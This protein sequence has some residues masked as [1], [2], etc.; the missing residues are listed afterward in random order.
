MNSS[1]GDTTPSPGPGAGPPD[2]G[3]WELPHRL[4]DDG[5]PA[6]QR[7]TTISEYRAYIDRQVHSFLGYQANQHADYS[8]QLSWMLDRSVNNLGDPYIDG[9]FTVN[10]KAFERDVLDYFARLWRAKGRD[11][12]DLGNAYWGYLLS[13]GSTEAN[14]YGLWNAR[15]YLKG[16]ALVSDPANPERMLWMSAV[17]ASTVDGHATSGADGTAPG[18]TAQFTPVAFYSADTHYSLT[19]AARVLGIPTFAEVGTSAYR[20]QC[21]LGGAWP[22]EVPSV[23]GDAGPGSIDVDKL[24]ELV[25]FFAARGHPALIT[26]NL[27]T[28]FKGAYDPVGEIA[29]RIADIMRSHSMYERILQVP[30]GTTTP[31]TVKR[32]GFWIHVDGALGAAYLPYLRMARHAGDARAADLPPVPEFD[33]SVEDVFSISVS[34]HKWI[35]APWPCGV[36]MTKTKYQLKPPD[37]PAYVGSPDTTFAGSRDGF[38]AVLLWEHLARY[39]QDEQIDRALAAQEIAAYAVDKL[40]ALGKKLRR[41]LYVGRTPLALTVRFLKPVEAVVFKYSLSTETYISDQWVDYAHLFVMPGVTKDLID[42]LIADL[43]ENGAFPE[44]PPITAR[45]TAAVAER[46]TAA[47]PLAGAAVPLTGRGFE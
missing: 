28:T 17:A 37:M 7:A 25:K 15:D 44:P 2:P 12:P 31:T 1:S 3:H 34:G 20:D 42:R 19:K 24:C 29:P 10:S 41:D 16:R 35:G 11:D 36:Y 47:T 21:P 32:H 6:S 27:G 23:G 8:D 14:L 43:G 22:D 40:T 9:N 13:M 33:F 46:R 45:A 39:T 18:S 5:V 26:L 30:N 38:S 4:G